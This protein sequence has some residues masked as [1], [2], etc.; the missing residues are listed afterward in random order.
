MSVSVYMFITR[1]E[2]LVSCLSAGA[3]SLPHSF[4]LFLG[5][6]KVPMCGACTVVGYV[7]LYLPVILFMMMMIT[8]L[9]S[10]LSPCSRKREEER[11]HKRGKG[12]RGTSGSH[13][14]QVYL[15]SMLLL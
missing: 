14:H 4:T 11:L 9:F 1:R 13:P 10:L 2:R 5:E 12:A 3:L 7:S 8:L 6:E 15:L